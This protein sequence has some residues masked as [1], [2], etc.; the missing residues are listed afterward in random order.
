MLLSYP[1]SLCSGPLE[2]VVSPLC[3]LKNL[4]PSALFLL[5][6]FPFSLFAFPS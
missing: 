5:M 3:L 2:A 1:R 4:I 6:A